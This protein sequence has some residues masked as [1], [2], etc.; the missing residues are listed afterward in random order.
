MAKRRRKQSRKRRPTPRSKMRAAQAQKRIEYGLQ[1]H[2]SESSREKATKAQTEA[3]LLDSD[4]RLY[5][6]NTTSTQDKAKS[7]DKT[8][9]KRKDFWDDLGGAFESH[10][11]PNWE[12][13]PHHP[14]ID[15][16]QDVFAERPITPTEGRERWLFW[17]VLLIPVIAVFAVI[18]G[19]LW[20]TAKVRHDQR[21]TFDARLRTWLEQSVNTRV[22]WRG[23]RS[24]KKD[25]V[26]RKRAITALVQ[27]L[28]VSKQ[29]RACRS[30]QALYYFAPSLRESR[31]HTTYLVSHLLYR[32]LRSNADRGQQP[33]THQLQVQGKNKKNI[34]IRHL[35]CPLAVELRGIDLQSL[36]LSTAQFPRA[37][38]QYADFTAS[39]LLR[40]NFRHA[41][42]Q[43][44]VFFRAK[45]QH[46][47]L[48]HAD[49]S[50]ADF[51]Q[52]DL[53]GAAL[54]QSKFTFAKIK[55]AL[56]NVRQLQGLTHKAFAHATCLS[57]TQAE[58]CHR[59][60]RER[61]QAAAIHLKAQGTTKKAAKAPTGCPTQ[62]E[63]PI[64]SLSAGKMTS[65]RSRPSR[66]TRPQSLPSSRKLRGLP[67]T[68][69]TR[70][71]TRPSTRRRDKQELLM[72]SPSPA[73]PPPSTL[74]PN[75]VQ[76]EPRPSSQPILV[77]MKKQAKHPSTKRVVEK[78]H[79]QKKAALKRGSC[80]TWITQPGPIRGS[81]L[82]STP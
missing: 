79:E 16:S 4:D 55:G 23:L 62:L 82:R 67:R 1:E 24:I 20:K 22:A 3:S 80:P 74:P 75:T 45:L 68:S 57:P 17:F 7:T 56:L 51:Q 53:R 70:P 27:D 14:K 18:G 58:S 50:D 76:N 21:M 28:T 40:A 46:A 12:G 25:P 44:S 34:S 10:H 8:L 42:L 11:D 54:T 9:K 36:D 26:Q 52:A 43:H 81:V 29:H 77:N 49:L 47:Q 37:R 59:W 6:P 38:L 65:P 33:S 30:L 60:H 48:Q 63:G 64:L 31:D 78:K 39:S 41:Q 66:P 61:A 19:A 32:S 72:N 15:P 13:S 73:K 2:E 5:S 69:S 71:S 35:R